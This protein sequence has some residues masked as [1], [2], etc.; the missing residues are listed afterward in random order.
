MFYTLT[1][2][3][4]IDMNVT[5]K[6]SIEPNKVNRTCHTVYSPN[7]KGVN[8]SLVLSHFHIDTCVLGFFGGFSGKFILDELKARKINTDPVLVEEPTRINL[9]INDKNKEYKIVNEGSF[10]NNEAKKALLFKLSKLNNNDWIIISGSLPRGV[11]ESIYPEILTTLQKNGVK[12]VLDISSKF[13]LEAG[14]YSPYLIKP[15]DEELYELFNYKVDDDLSAKKALQAL[16]L[17]GFQNILLTMG[18]KGSYFYDGKEFWFCPVKKVK[19]VSSA[20]AGDSALAAFISVWGNN[21]EIERALI[22]SAATGANVAESDALGDLQN[23]SKYEKEISP[24]K[25]D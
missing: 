12:V 5:A 15:N 14:K 11:D 18:A 6:A 1:M 10:I 16:H 7:G 21:Q 22:R 19:L 13:L 3:P 24:K 2:N 8:V 25:L 9:F 23:V 17:K 20:C 4:A